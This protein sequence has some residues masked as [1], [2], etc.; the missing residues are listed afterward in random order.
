MLHCSGSLSLRGPAG[1]S[2]ADPSGFSKSGPRPLEP[3][4]QMKSD[5]EKLIAAMNRSRDST[6]ALFDRVV[7]EASIQKCPHKGFR[8]MLWHLAHVGTF[9]EFW[10]LIRLRGQAPVSTRYQVLFDPIQTPREES[11]HLPSRREIETYLAMI[12]SR[13]EQLFGSPRAAGTVSDGLDEDYTLQM[14]LEHEYQHQETLAYLLQMLPHSSKRNPECPRA[15]D[16]NAIKEDSAMVSVKGGRFILGG[17]GQFVYD[18]EEPVHSVELADFRIDRNLVT[19]GEFLEFLLDGGYE[20]RA[21]WSETGWAW[22]E[23]NAIHCPQYW[24]PGENWQTKEMFTMEPLRLDYPVTGVSWHEADAY[25]RSVGRRLPT[26]AEWERAASWDAETSTKRRFAWGDK[27]PDTSVC[28]FG[29][30]FNGPTQAGRFPGGASPVGCLDMS[31]NVWEWTATTFGPYPGF[32][33]HPYPEYSEL[34]FDGDHRVLKGGSWMTRAPLLRT[35]FR[36]F[37]RPGFRFAFA[38]FRCCSD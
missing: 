12:R 27:E 30:H 22:K 34:W 35:S 31:G 11:E 18:N 26:E 29:G 25:S 5:R 15:T 10:L 6:F 4:S 24:Q 8:P 23:A 16:S 19:N 21:L 2:M 38:G 14:V 9:E 13:V 33:A 20:N 36:N 7:D 1:A 32:R 28:N 17:S 3:C 37:F